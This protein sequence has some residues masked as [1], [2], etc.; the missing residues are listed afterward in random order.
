MPMKLAF[1]LAS[2]AFTAALLPALAQAA[3]GSESYGIRA[4]ARTKCRVQLEQGSAQVS[5]AGLVQLG[6]MNEACNNREG[7]RIVLTHAAGLTGGRVLL[8][9]QEIPLSATGETV[10]V[11]ADDA[12]FRSRDV[13][14]DFGAGASG[15]MTLSFRAEPKGPIY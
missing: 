12:A 5:G 15:P 4:V 13:A 2:L 7:Y 1:G 10:I 6:A 11:D 14:V 9:G 3:D 8:D